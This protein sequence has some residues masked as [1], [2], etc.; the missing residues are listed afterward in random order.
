MII[1]PLTGLLLPKSYWEH[2][3]FLR[4]LGYLVFLGWENVNGT[5]MTEEELI[6]LASSFHIET[7]IITLS[8]ISII[9][10]NTPVQVEQIH[11]V[12]NALTRQ[13]CT[14]EQA[15][16]IELFIQSGRSDV[17]A[18][19]EQLLVA[20]VLAFQYGQFGLPED[21]SLHPF[22]RFLLG[23]NDLLNYEQPGTSIQDTMINLA[24]RRQAIALSGQPRYQLAR[25]FDLLVT[26]SR[27]KSVEICDLETT[28]QSHASMSIEEYMAFGFL[29]LEPFLNARTVYDLQQ[30]GFLQRIHHIESQVRDPQFLER[31]RSLFSHDANAFRA[32]WS[33]KR[34]QSLIGLSFLPF[35]QYPLFRMSNGSAIPIDF[36]FL[37]DKMSIGAYWLLHEYF[38]TDDR[39]NGARKFTSYVGMLF[40]DYIT[41]LLKRT[42]PF[43]TQRFYDEEEIL[44]ASKITRRGKQQK[45]CDGILVSGKSLVLFEIT[46][47]GL[48]IQTLIEGDPAK[49]QKDITRKFKQ[50]IEQLNETFDRLAQHTLDIP[51]WDRNA[52]T[53][54]YPVLVL[55]QPFPQ[56]AATWE[57]LGECAKIPGQYPFGDSE[58]YVY[59]HAPQILAAEE[60]EMLE[61]LLQTGSLLLPNLLTEKMGNEETATISMK[62]YLLRWKR[63]NEQPNQQ[64]MS[65][66]D[67]ATD[68]LRDILSDHIAF[69]EKE[70]DTP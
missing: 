17:I 4:H 59:V 22:G 53:D 13:I 41:D 9:L 12:Q 28:F 1:D 23:I 36:S 47:T 54:V 48:P 19:Q 66:Y 57:K 55:H 43:R 2:Q 50:K 62:D 11:Q 58:T 24:S 10:T 29:Y 7:T 30:K 65:L 26:R 5:A 61:P 34:G 37:L 14:P 60:L 27:K 6:E 31:C 63:V 20:A 16:R 44:Q 8:A 46:D 3:A 15:H 52:I 51:G 39:Q 35:Q 56:H 69:V 68:R 32:L 21:T 42:F 40:Q 45:C 67:K 18:H 33:D 64:M 25:Y 70:E 49:F 38:R